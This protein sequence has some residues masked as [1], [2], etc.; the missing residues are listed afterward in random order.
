MGVQGVQ[1]SLGHFDDEEAAARAYPK[2]AIE[3]G[4]LDQINFH[5]HD[6]IPSASP[7]PQQKISRFRGVC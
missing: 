1:K 3:R 7:A 4:L 5:D 2:A 6:L